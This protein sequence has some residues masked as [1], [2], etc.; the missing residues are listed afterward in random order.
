V[1]KLF[2]ITLPV[3]LEYHQ[4]PF[5]RYHVHHKIELEGKDEGEDPIQ[6]CHSGHSAEMQQERAECRHGGGNRR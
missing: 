3:A 5:Y 1:K 2:G 4:N 6:P